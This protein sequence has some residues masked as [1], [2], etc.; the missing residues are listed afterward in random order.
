MSPGRIV[1]AVGVLVGAALIAVLGLPRAAAA[2]EN[3][4]SLDPDKG[5]LEGSPID[6]LP[7]NI[8]LLDIRLPDGG[9]PMRADWS[10]DGE[11]I[12]L[13]D[14]PI[15]DVWEHDLATGATRNL[16]GSFLPGGVLRA[17][18]L[19]NGDL[20]LCAPA[21]RSADDPEGDRF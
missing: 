20:V 9:T 13:L 5:T 18:H 1:R 2:Q 11:R 14:A 15:G 6:H 17:H 4:V 8:R 3:P 10:P 21:E 19:T 16:T 12:V 7:P